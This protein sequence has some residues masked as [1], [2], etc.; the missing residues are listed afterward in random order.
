[1]SAQPMWVGIS[2]IDGDEFWSTS[3][4]N[5]LWDPENMYLDWL[6]APERVRRHVPPEVVVLGQGRVVEDIP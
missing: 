4:G 6:V 1:M 3:A 5:E 2:D